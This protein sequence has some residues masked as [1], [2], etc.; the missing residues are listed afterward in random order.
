MSFLKKITIRNIFLLGM[1]TILTSCGGGGGGSSSTEID[2]SL[3]SIEFEA[4]TS[5]DAPQSVDISVTYKGDGV[6]VGYAPGETEPHWLEV[7]TIESSDNSA[8]FRL[9]AYHDGVPRNYSSNVRFVTG[10]SDGTNIKFQDVRVNFDVQQGF[11]VFS[12]VDSFIANSIG[13]EN[14][15]ITL[16]DDVIQLFGDNP[17]WS[18]NKPD[19]VTITQESGVGDAILNVGIAPQNAVYGTNT[20][21]IVITDSVSGDEERIEITYELDHGSYTINTESHFFSVFNDTNEEQLISTIELEDDFNGTSS[22]N[23]FSWQLV[24]SSESWLTLANTSGT[25]SVNS[26]QPQIQINK[27]E[28]LSLI[29][30]EQYNATISIAVGSDFASQQV[31]EIEV[32][33]FIQD[34]LLTV[35]DS[36]ANQFSFKVNDAAFSSL[37]KS[38]AISDTAEKSIYIVDAETGFTVSSYQ[39]DTMPETVSISPNGKYLYVSLLIQEH[40]FF[41]ENPGG[42]IA[43]ID[44]E[45][46]RLINQFNINI[47]PW[48]IE[49]NDDGLVFVSP[50]SGQFSEL[51][52]YNALTGLLDIEVLSRHQVNLALSVDQQS[53]HS[54]TT[55]VSPQ[56]ISTYELVTHEDG[57]FLSEFSLYDF[58]YGIGN[59]FWLD[60]E[61]NVIVT[62]LSNV[63][64]A[65]DLTY[66]SEINSSD[67]FIEHVTFDY[68][69][70]KSVFIGSS[71]NYDTSE[72]VTGIIASVDL[73]NYDNYQVITIS[74]KDPKFIFNNNGK[75][76]VIEESNNIFTLVEY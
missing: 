4:K 71:L 45:K 66:K 41:Q 1:L 23:V 72:F 36:V 31:H 27:A 43:I 37:D 65:S 25:T 73:P 69:N 39:F 52:R 42:Q 24:S 50:G 51:Q 47:D 21:E 57:S 5:D 38:I 13:R 40:D 22:E 55:D 8:R 76:L 7:S 17:I 6:I 2:V 9:S 26:E 53:I 16:N 58:N 34:A 49:G 46:R 44:I 75:Y 29:S 74:A 67:T 20:G 61:N 15:A 68:K 10:E 59:N 48:D 35:S 12:F 28:L 3:S 14:N 64:D 63:F 18:I 19:W 60:I 62:S 32:S 30:G 11:V 33:A 54:V 56:S 70:N